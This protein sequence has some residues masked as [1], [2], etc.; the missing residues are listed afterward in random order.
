MWDQANETFLQLEL[1]N[2]PQMRAL[3]G[4]PDEPCRTRVLHND[5]D[6][7]SSC[8]LGKDSCKLRLEDT[9]SSRNFHTCSNPVSLEASESS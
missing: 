3:S 5:H 1:A 6:K 9:L 7:R 8:N 4:L 2:P